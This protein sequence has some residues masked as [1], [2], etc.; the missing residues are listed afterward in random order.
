MNACRQGMLVLVTRS[1]VVSQERQARYEPRVLSSVA[2][3]HDLTKAC[4]RRRTA[5]APASLRLPAAPDARR[6]LADLRLAY[7]NYRTYNVV[8]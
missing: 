3:L 7:R 2:V 4:K 8:T 6:S 5:S 1:A